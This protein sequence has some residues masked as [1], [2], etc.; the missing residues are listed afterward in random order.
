MVVAAHLLLPLLPRWLLSFSLSGGVGWELDGRCVHPRTSG[1][2]LPLPL[3]ASRPGSYPCVWFLLILEPPSAASLKGLRTGLRPLDG[4][5]APS[6]LWGVSGCP[7]GRPLCPA[8]L[9]DFSF[10]GSS[11]FWASLLGASIWLSSLVASG[12][13]PP[14]SL[15]MAWVSSSSWL[16]ARRSSTESSRRFAAPAALSSSSC[17]LVAGLPRR[18]PFIHMGQSSSA[19]ALGAGLSPPLAPGLLLLLP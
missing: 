4:L 6:L 9:Y 17:P 11:F 13:A 12:P 18:S 1:R 19:R 15:S 5:P 2:T 14:S 7:P 16:S 10:T 8:L 3:G